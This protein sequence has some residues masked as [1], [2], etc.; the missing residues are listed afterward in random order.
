MSLMSD[1]GGGPRLE[2]QQAVWGR[3]ENR[4]GHLGRCSQSTRGE[5][6]SR[7]FDRKKVIGDE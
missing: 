2:R 3:V 1:D 7:R 6:H 5:E 4:V